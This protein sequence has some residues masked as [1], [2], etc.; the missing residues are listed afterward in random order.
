[1]LELSSEVAVFALA[2]GQCSLLKKL[3]ST[4][5]TGIIQID[6]AGLRLHPDVRLVAVTNRGADTI[7][8][9][10]LTAAG[11]MAFVDEADAGS[12]PRDLDFSPC[13]RWVVVANQRASDLSVFS[14]TEAE[15]L[16]GGAR[17]GNVMAPSCVRFVAWM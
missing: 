5:R 16:A 17:V 11:G 4:A 1:M 13:G 3:P 9:F 7:S 8:L 2:D 14:V 10:Q 15:R 6:P 12:F